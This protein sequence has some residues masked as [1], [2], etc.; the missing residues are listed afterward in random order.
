MNVAVRFTGKQFIMAEAG[1]WIVLAVM[2]QRDIAKVE[3]ASAFPL[4]LT[5]VL[6][7]VPVL[8]MIGD[9]IG[10]GALEQV[11]FAR[12]WRACRVAQA[13][14]FVLALFLWLT[15]AYVVRIFLP[16]QH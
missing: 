5:V 9:R 16:S 3:N 14:L 1:F 8:H 6:I 12:F 13:G 15:I 2:L 10:C 11:R 7:G 4:S